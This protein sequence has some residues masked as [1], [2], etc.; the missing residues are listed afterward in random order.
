MDIAWSVA[1]DDDGSAYISGETRGNLA[2]SNPSI[3]STDAWLAKYSRMGA[4]LW[5]KQLGTS[6]WDYSFAVA[7]DDENN[8]YISG[9]TTGALGGPNRGSN[10]AWSAKYSAD[11]MLRWTRQLGTSEGDASNGVAADHD[12]NV[13]FSG[14]T[15]GALTSAQRGQ[16]DAFVAKYFT[17][18]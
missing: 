5:T 18:R 14:Y 17:R 7:I 4:L 16:G 6:D 9:A 3:G 8:A 12:G 15:Y 10:D 11:G 2:T 1:T 13:Y